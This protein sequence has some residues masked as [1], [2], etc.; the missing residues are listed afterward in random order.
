MYF[1]FPPGSK[2]KESNENVNEVLDVVNPNVEEKIEFSTK[3]SWI[4]IP[5]ALCDILG[6][7]IMLLGLLR[8][9]AS[10]YQMLRGSVI[11]FTGINSRLFLK[12]KISWKKWGSI[13]I[14]SAGLI[15][16]GL[17]DLLQSSSH[18]GCIPY[19]GSANFSAMQMISN[20]TDNATSGC[21]SDKNVNTEVY[22]DILVVFSQF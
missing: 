10:S 17:A 4:M 12:K 3:T 19:M 16:V 22:G 14:V 9:S 13:V 21:K 7:S 8:T 2:N 18:S 15:I 11:I 20:K 5:S 1:K 6:V